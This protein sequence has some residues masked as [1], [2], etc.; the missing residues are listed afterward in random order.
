MT[1]EIRL[2]NTTIINDFLIHWHNPD[3]DSYV[4]SKLLRTI[5]RDLKRVSV[6]ETAIGISVTKFVDD[7]TTLSTTVFPYTSISHYV[8]EWQKVPDYLE[9]EK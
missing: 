2:N 1:A 6:D 9:T 5:D 3:H 4:I 8:V 7:D